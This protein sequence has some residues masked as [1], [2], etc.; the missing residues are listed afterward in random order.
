MA[1]WL[2]LFI[3]LVCTHKLCK[4]QH[5]RYEQGMGTEVKGAEVKDALNT[6]YPGT[7]TA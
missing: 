3:V 7:G 1:D 2:T 5:V 4:V 6:A